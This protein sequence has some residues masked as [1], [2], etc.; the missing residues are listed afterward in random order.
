MLHLEKLTWPELDALDRAQ[1]VVF[2]PFSPMEEH[3]PHLPIGTDFLD[4]QHFAETIA[5]HLEARRPHV[6]ALL[7]PPV[8][9]GAGTIP[10]R[11]SVNIST[12]LVFA[13][14]RQIASAFAQDGF[15][16]IVF[17]N[18]HLGAWHLLALENAA[19]WVSRHHHVHAIAP[20]ATL[21]RAMI[22]GGDLSAALGDRLSAEGKAE[23]QKAA[24]GGMLETSVMLQLHPELVRP[25]FAELPRLTGRA[26][27]GWRGRKP[28]GWAGYLG[29]PAQGAAEWGA[30]VVD[31][32]ATSGAQLIL[33]MLDEGHVA[34]RSA[35][36]LPR[37]PF[38]LS[39]RQVGW[40]AM[41]ATLGV[42]ATL[43][44]N[45]I[46]SQGSKHRG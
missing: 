17:T 45:Q 37:V 13:V 21:A 23:L 42:G 36:L 15:R 46:F 7:M 29:N 41:A 2:I 19:A 34:A 22:W 8:P 27:L 26:M 12:D 4:A 35:R 5:Q 25:G 6:T 20:T 14:A 28:K 30:A 40:L 1:T 44:A 39:A 11:G 9:L 24:H 10:M 33:R 18:G 43:L 3:G 32:L 31:V 16:Y 38:W